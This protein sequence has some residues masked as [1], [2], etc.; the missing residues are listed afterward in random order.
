MRK[1]ITPAVSSLLAA[2]A[3]SASAVPAQVPAK[4][5]TAQANVH[6]MPAIDMGTLQRER[7]YRVYLP[8]GYEGSGKRYPVLYMH[9][10]QNL[11]DDATS[12]VGEW[13]VDE[14]LNQLSKTCGLD[15][16]VVGV[17]HGDKLRMTEL[18]PY[19]NERFGKGEGDAYVDFLVN[20]LKPHIDREFRTLPDR[21]HTAIMGSSMGG[22]ISNHAINR[23]PQV[24]GIAGIFSPSYWIAPQIFAAT[25]SNPALKSTRI[26]LA[27]GAK[28]GEAMTEGFNQMSQLLEQHAGTG[29][30]QAQ[31]EADG[32]HNEASWNRIFPEAV[33]WLFSAPCNKPL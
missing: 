31:L 28:E 32:E 7:V 1:L 21:E 22:L 10:G 11:F 25:E 23:H 17:D 18:N 6:V 4:T 2:L 9:D 29:Q 3:M 12:Y 16:I 14:A 33:S 30:W 8:A 13:G 19:D 15:M 5:S 20:R 27:T 24:F 26:Y